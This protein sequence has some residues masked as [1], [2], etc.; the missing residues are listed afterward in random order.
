MS[1]N[2]W[3]ILVA[4]TLLVAQA[5]NA[6]VH[7]HSGM[8]P[9]GFVFDDSDEGRTVPLQQRLWEISGS[10]RAAAET[11]TNGLAGD[12]PCRNIDLM[13]HIPPADMCGQSSNLNDIWGWTDLATGMEVAIVGRTNGTSFV[14]VTDP[15]APIVLGFLPSHDSGS[16]SWRDIKVYQDHAFIV[17]DGSGNRNHGLQV[18]DLTTLVGIAPRSLLSATAH[19][20]GFGN[21]HNIAI[22]E[23]SGFAYVVGS[24]TFSGGLY[25]LDVSVPSAPTFAGFYSD[26]GYTHDV[27]CVNYQGPDTRYTG[28]E[29]CFAFNEDTLTIVDV[30]DKNN[31]QQ[32]ARQGYNGSQYTHQGWLLD[33]NQRYLIMNDE[34]DE[35]FDENDT[36]TYVFDVNSLTAPFLT[37]TYVAGT[38]AIDHNLYTRDGYVYQ[39]N[40]RAGL[41]VLATDQ[42]TSGILEERAYFDSIPCSDTAQFSGS[43]SNYVYLPSGNVLVSDIATGLFVL[44]PDMLAIAAN[45]NDVAPIASPVCR[46]STKQQVVTQQRLPSLSLDFFMQSNECDADVGV[47]GGSGGSGGSSAIIFECF[48]MLFLLGAVRH[49][50]RSATE[51]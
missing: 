12:Y 5:N 48:A 44:R 31:P 7:A 50:R 16:D 34:L 15:V 46:S 32:L 4:V 23:D 25:I 38:A 33:T 20:D 49:T 26:D 43:W 2:F 28:R 11:C 14:D 41:R 30:T 42:I 40:Y 13:A 21:A 27:Q 10:S 37:A 47:I 18:F 22:N 35:A 1:R 8:F 39:S 3:R 24:N 29:V 9:D 17:A 51:R 36:T 19:H 6:W 45:A